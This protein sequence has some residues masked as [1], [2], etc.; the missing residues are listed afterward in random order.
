V[1]VAMLFS[2][3]TNVQK[4]RSAKDFRRYGRFSKKWS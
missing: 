2:F 4:L 1:V 3:L